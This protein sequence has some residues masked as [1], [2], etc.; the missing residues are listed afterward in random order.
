M[1]NEGGGTMSAINKSTCG[2]YNYIWDKKCTICDLQLIN[3]T[4]E[5]LKQGNSYILTKHKLIDEFKIIRITEKFVL[6]ENSR[7]IRQ[8]RYK[9]EFVDTENAIDDVYQILEDLGA[10]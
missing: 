1:I 7:G 5:M 6:M 10:Y 2:H 3:K 4:K 9:T 8:W